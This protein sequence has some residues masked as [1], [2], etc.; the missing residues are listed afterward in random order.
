V[1]EP[2]LLRRFR[3]IGLAALPLLAS[4]C[5]V[6]VG[7]EFQDPPGNTAPY[8]ASSNPVE[9]SVLLDVSPMIEVV[10][11]DAN[12]NDTLMG[13]WFIDYPPF[14]AAVTRMVQEFRLPGTGKDER[15][16][17]RFAPNCID[18]QIA[19]GMVSH[20]VT[21]SVA[22]RPFLPEEQSPP[23]LRFD[24]VAAEG[25]VLRATWILNLTCE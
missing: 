25:F 2:R 22:D 17:V 5:V 6:P 20:R 18:G 3:R 21:L 15:G 8:L 11:G 10:L 12:H 13:R 24:S 9:G 16:K 23:D 14:D 19:P 7:P 4:A 1:N